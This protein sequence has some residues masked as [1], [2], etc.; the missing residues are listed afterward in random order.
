M[1]GELQL[2]VLTSRLEAEYS[3]KAGF[4]AAPYE[5]ARW[6]QATIPPSSRPSCKSNR[7]G[8]A[9]DRDG[10][11]VYLARNAWELDYIQ[12]QYPDIRFA[13]TREQ[14]EI[15]A[16]PRPRHSPRLAPSPPS[17][18]PRPPKGGEGRGEGVHQPGAS[19]DRSFSLQASHP[20]TLTLSPVPGARG[21]ERK[22]RGE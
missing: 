6:V 16:G 17:F 11:P 12:R 21:I 22:G 15:W 5:T 1:V 7:G 2:E 4:E 18:P 20:L 14:P 3:I 10:A 9:E 13:K 19:P 8:L